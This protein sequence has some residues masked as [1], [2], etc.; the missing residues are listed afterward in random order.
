[1]SGQE[2]ADAGLPVSLRPRASVKESIGIPGTGA[3]ERLLTACG[4]GTIGTATSNEWLH[5]RASH[6]SANQVAWRIDDGGTVR[7]DA[8]AENIDVF[9][10]SFK[11]RRSYLSAVGCDGMLRLTITNDVTNI[12]PEADSL[13]KLYDVDFGAP[14]AAPSSRVVIAGEEVA[15]ARPHPEVPDG[16]VLPAP[17]HHIAEAVVEHRRVRQSPG[18]F[19]RAKILNSGADLAVMID[20]SAA[21]QPRP[22][23]WVFPTRGWWALGIEPDTAIAMGMHEAALR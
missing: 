2:L 3:T 4:F 13:S 20:W 8:V 9:D 17:T 11:V 23:H 18:G 21:T 16:S 6:M 22:H 19:A 12:G 5:R 14:L 15:G 1:M 10:P 7:L